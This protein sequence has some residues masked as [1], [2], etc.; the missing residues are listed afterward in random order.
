M[1]NNS[2]FL[3]KGST[4]QQRP[5][6]PLPKELCGWCRL[7]LTSSAHSVS[8]TS[9]ISA[10]AETLRSQR[11]SSKPVK[12][13]SLSHRHLQQALL[14]WLA[15]VQQDTVTHSTR[16]GHTRFWPP[17]LWLGHRPGYPFTD[18]A[19]ICRSPQQ[20]RLMEVGICA[21]IRG[22]RGY[23]C[24]N[25]KSLV[26]TVLQITDV[27]ML[28]KLTVMPGMPDAHTFVLQEWRSLEWV[29]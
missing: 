20:Y 2:F 6:S 18:H 13:V 8:H 29:D 22:Y 1:S 9:S 23:Y 14:L 27:C 16:G 19:S 4:S 21:C 25:Q 5:V 3:W 26:N 12:P 10:C 28:S 24:A 11:L 15:E 7:T 17:A